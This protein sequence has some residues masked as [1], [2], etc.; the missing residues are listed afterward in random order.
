[1]PSALLAVAF[2]K[3]SCIQAGIDVESQAGSKPLAS[4]TRS[5][6]RNME[7]LE[8]ETSTFLEKLGH[9]LAGSGALLGIVLVAFGGILSATSGRERVAEMEAMPIVTGQDLA[10]STGALRFSARIVSLPASD[11]PRPGY[12]A[13][14]QETRKSKGALSPQDIESDKRATFLAGLEVETLD[15]VR[16][17]VASSPIIADSDHRF[18]DHGTF[19]DYRVLVW[20]L[21]TGDQVGISGRI[22]VN[23]DGGLIVREAIFV[24]GDATA[25]PRFYEELSRLPWLWGNRVLVV[26]VLCLLP[27]GYIQLRRV[28][29]WLRR[30]RRAT[31]AADS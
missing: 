6:G 5:T 10:D 4:R 12:V 19:K 27:W 31:H 8:P 22:N 24:A 9:R 28:G 29:R 20:C 18:G 13:C 17:G 7:N 16:V 21:K 23:Q 26:G 2:A 14:M 1:M 3:F 11:A 30:R 15:G 25:L